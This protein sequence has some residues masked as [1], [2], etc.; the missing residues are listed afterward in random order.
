MT[1]WNNCEWALIKGDAAQS[2]KTLPNESVD[3]TITSPPYYWQRDYRV[4]GQLGHEKTID[5]YI[6]A[7][8]A[9]TRRR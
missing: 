4:K 2:L 6:G 5:A 9:T 7:L 1:T 8:V 3:C